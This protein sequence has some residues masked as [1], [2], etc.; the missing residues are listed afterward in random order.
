VKHPSPF[1]DSRHAFSLIEIMVTVGLLSVIILG[2]LAV[3]SQTQRA[4]KNSM[5]DVDVLESGRIS[6]E[7]IAREIEQTTPVRVPLTVNSNI[8]NFFIQPS[9]RFPGPS[10]QA[11]PGVAAAGAS[12][13][14]RTNTFE[15]FFFL[16]KVNKNWIGTGYEVIPEYQGA[17]LG[18]LYRYSSNIVSG[19]S[20]TLGADLRLRTQQF[21]PLTNLSRIADGIVHLRVK[22]FDDR[23]RWI[24]PLWSTNQAN[25]VPQSQVL[26]GRIQFGVPPSTVPWLFDEYFYSN[27][28]PAYV[29]LEL[30]ILQKATLDRFRAIGQ[31]NLAAQLR[32]LSNHVADVH[33]FRQ[34]VPIRNADFS[35]FK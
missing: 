1:I 31:E 26:Q 33:V 10:F 17:P 6:M 19:G 5:N 18:A 20:M 27:V 8:L 3:F 24:T 4:F 14:L 9:R 15:R 13:Q 34:R 25:Q 23:G 21:A 11:L 2:L 12:T 7:M 32:Y 29:E 30:G 28:V 22:A 35:V 16:S